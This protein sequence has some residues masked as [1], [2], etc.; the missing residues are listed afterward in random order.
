MF[1]IVNYISGIVGSM[2]GSFYFFHGRPDVM[3]AENQITPNTLPMV[4]L[5]RPIDEEHEPIIGGSTNVTYTMTIAFCNYKEDQNKNYLQDD[6]DTNIIDPMRT[7][8]ENFLELVKQ[9]VNAQGNERAA[10]IESFTMQ[11][12]TNN[13]EFNMSLSGML[14]TIGI[15]IIDAYSLCV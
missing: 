5:F 12:F 3:N 8:A 13:Q 1:D 14:L 6:Y 9:S 10:L 4:L 11:D 7:A 2:T 15:K